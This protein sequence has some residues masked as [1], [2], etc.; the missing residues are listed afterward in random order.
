M[1]PGPV[2]ADSLQ[3]ACRASIKTLD[4]AVKAYCLNH[5]KIPD[6]LETLFESDGLAGGRH[7][8]NRDFLTDPWGNPFQYTVES[9]KIYSIISLGADG[10][11]GGTGENA[12]IASG[13]G[14]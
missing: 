5:N 1:G 4:G 9:G 3:E 7:L 13:A 8:E 11:E 10:V 12:D 14:N 6:S 2:S